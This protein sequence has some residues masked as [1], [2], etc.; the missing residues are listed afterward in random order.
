MSARP[1]LLALSLLMAACGDRPD[2]APVFQEAPGGPGSM[3]RA[4]RITGSP[5][6][7]AG[8][9]SQ[10]ELAA[11]AG[12][13]VLFAYDSSDISPEGQQTLT[14]QSGWLKR[15]PNI[16]VLIEGH[17]DE[18]GTR[19]YNLSLG[20]R[21]AEA[22]KNSLMALGISAS[23]ISTIS[24]GKERPEVPHSDEQSYAQNRRAVTVVN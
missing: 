12:D 20:E 1:L 9:G 13:R 11:T 6:A 14:R 3:G 24:Y 16:A 5:L 23:R 8:S 21:R 19:E 10:Q 4:D 17:A 15:Y 7:P 2:P 18:R 22:V